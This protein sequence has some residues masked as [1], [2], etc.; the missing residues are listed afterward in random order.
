MAGLKAICGSH[1]TST[2]GGLAATFWFD[3][4][5]P[6]VV[7]QIFLRRSEATLIRLTISL[8]ISIPLCIYVVL[9]TATNFGVRVFAGYETNAA[10]QCLLLTPSSTAC[11]TTQDAL[12]ISR[13]NAVAILEKTK[14]RPER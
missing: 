12:A 9:V 2:R 14:S 3:R 4:L 11:P 1:F 13:G 8:G 10:T 6:Y 5:A 7:D